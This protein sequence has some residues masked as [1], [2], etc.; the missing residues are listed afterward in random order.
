MLD[1]AGT[2][3]DYETPAEFLAGLKLDLYQDEVFVLTPNGHV[4]C[5]P[6]GATPWTSPTRCT[7]RWGTDAPGRG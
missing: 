5:L 3:E 2:S 6:R 1:L 7:P 4:K